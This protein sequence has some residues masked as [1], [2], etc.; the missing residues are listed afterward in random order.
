L[1]SGIGGVIVGEDEF[2]GVLRR[3]RVDDC[4]DG[5]VEESDV[6]LLVIDGHDER[7]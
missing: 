4:G 7:D 3:E 6:V 5:L 2:E 1:G